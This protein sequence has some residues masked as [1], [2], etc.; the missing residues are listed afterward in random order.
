MFSAYILASLEIKK[1]GEKKM[2][3]KYKTIRD[4]EATSP[5]EAKM[6]ALE[7]LIGTQEGFTK[8]NFEKYV[9]SELFMSDTPDDVLRTAKHEIAKRTK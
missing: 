3:E 5:K 8:E 9:V 6:L 7:S 2:T 1:I 4:I